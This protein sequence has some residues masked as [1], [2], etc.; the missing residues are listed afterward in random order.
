MRYTHDT[1]SVDLPDNW[2]VEENDECLTL[3]DPDGVGALQVSSYFKESGEVTIEDLIDFAEVGSPEKIDLPFLKGIFKKAIE[4]G[5]VFLSWWLCSA[6]HLIYATYICGTE[7]EAI[8]TKE[9]EHIIQSLRS[10]YA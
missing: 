6:N 7:Y 10:H 2:R 5:N 3:Y 8:E 1:W 4:G 9:R